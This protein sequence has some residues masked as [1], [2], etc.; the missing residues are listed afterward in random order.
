MITKSDPHVA[1]HENLRVLYT[2]C[3]TRH[4]KLGLKVCART[5][6]LSVSMTAKHFAAQQVHRFCEETN[7]YGKTAANRD[8]ADMHLLSSTAGGKGEE[9]AGGEGG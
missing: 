2:R 7:I 1:R 6:C 3:L 9:A 5:R 4:V 8:V